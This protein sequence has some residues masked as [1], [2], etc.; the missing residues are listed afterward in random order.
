MN[1]LVDPLVFAVP[2][3]TAS[4]EEL[5]SFVKYLVQWSDEFTAGQHSFM[6][7]EACVFALQDADCYPFIDRLQNLWQYAN[8][9][10]LE[11]KDVFNAC[12]KVLT[13]MPYLEDRIPELAEIALDET[14]VSV[15]PDLLTRQPEI[16]ASAFQQ[17]LGQVAYAEAKISETVARNLLLLTYPIEGS[18][19]AEIWG[20][21]LAES[22]EI[23]IR[24]EISMV[25]DPEGMLDYM[26]LADLW[27]DSRQALKWQARRMGEDAVF[28][29]FK[30]APEFN[31][32]IKERATESQQALLETIFRKCVYLLTRQWTAIKAHE[33]GQP[34]HRIGKWKAYRLVITEGNTGW[35]VHYWRRGDEF[36]LMQFGPHNNYDIDAPKELYD[37]AFS[38]L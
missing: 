2:S 26:E 32:S 37:E 25:Y 12:I 33:L 30:V 34:Q 38:I 29:P 3:L 13:N 4:Q 36:Y 21:A 22:G 24:A 31:L 11:C 18:S 6:L 16:V 27:E 23:A 1:L 20:R 14:T 5:T 9:T 10:E 17:T 19:L 28:A 7:S 15:R 8:E 35:R